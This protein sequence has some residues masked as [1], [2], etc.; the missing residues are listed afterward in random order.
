LISEIVLQILRDTPNARILLTAQANPAV[1]NAMDRLRELA[2]K[3]MLDIRTL[4]L[5]RS[6]SG[7]GFGEF[8][9][10][11]KAWIEETKESARVGFEALLPKLK[12]EQIEPVRAALTNWDNKLH[13]ANDVRTDYAQAVHIYGVTCLRAP[14]HGNSCGK[15]NL[16]GLS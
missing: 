10:S 1:D 6:E 3:E 11:F 16:I 15:S 5:T 8:E 2:A 13:W 12:P 14:T 7:R 4:R 9:D